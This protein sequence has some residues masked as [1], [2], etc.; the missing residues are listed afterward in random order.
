[1]ALLGE[2]LGWGGEQTGA[3]PSPL[4]PLTIS[5]CRV[6][7]ADWWVV[8][9]FGGRSEGYIL[10]KL[11]ER[12]LRRAARG[13]L[14]GYAVTRVVKPRVRYGRE[15]YEVTWSGGAPLSVVPAHL[16]RTAFPSEV[17]AFLETKKGGGDICKRLE[18]LL[19]CGQ[20]RQGHLPSRNEETGGSSLGQ[21]QGC[22]TPVKDDDE[23]GP[24][25]SKGGIPFVDLGSPT[26]ILPPHGGGGEKSSLLS[27]GTDSESDVE[28]VDAASFLQAR[29]RRRMGSKAGQVGD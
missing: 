28:C 10:P 3:H 15:Y 27:G 8:W 25:R 5:E 9:W 13:C 24:V 7:S 4:L 16:V 18:R 20:P 22:S 29:A 1:M 23:R 11:A 19:F 12:D 21:R 17:A 14:G 26:P 6:P 2:Q